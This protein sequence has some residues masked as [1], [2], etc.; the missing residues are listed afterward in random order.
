MRDKISQFVAKFKNG[1]EYSRVNVA[2]VALMP[3]GKSG[4]NADWK[5]IDSNNDGLSDKLLISGT[6]DMYDY[7]HIDTNK[8]AVNV[9][10]TVPEGSKIT[11][12]GL[13]ASPSTEYNP[14]NGELTWN[15]A[16]FRKASAGAVGKSV[17]VNYTWTKTSVKPGDVWYVRAHIAYTDANNQSHEI[18]GN[19]ITITA[20][21]DY[22]YIEKGTAAIRS[23]TY[24]AS[25]KKASFN[26]YL[27]VPDNAVIVKAGLVA[28]SGAN[29]DPEKAVLT[30]ANADYVKTSAGAAGKCVPVNYTWNKTN[31]NAG[32]VWY[33]RAYL[34]YTINDEEHTVYGTLTTLTA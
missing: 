31:V 2:F 13:V 25:A 9:Y 24:D 12:A 16:A 34:V 19:L 26:V 17:P 4:D 6:G 27:T 7:D 33:V 8:L 11:S 30:S 14:V 3:E 28:A 10:L 29:F 21:C 32:D 18:Y 15:N 23:A 20:G 22:D 5:L 1:N